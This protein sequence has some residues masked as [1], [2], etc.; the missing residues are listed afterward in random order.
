VDDTTTTPAGT[1]KYG[2]FQYANWSYIQ[3]MQVR[4]PHVFAADRDSA[5]RDHRVVTW[6]WQLQRHAFVDP[7]PATGWKTVAT[8]KRQRATAYEDAQAPFT[9]MRVYFD[10]K[11][12]APA[13][14][15]FS[16]ALLRALVVVKWYRPDGSVEA[17]VKLVP[18]YYR[19]KTVFAPD[20]TGGQPWCGL[21][22]TSG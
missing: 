20:F 8:S 10:G 19:L 1:C 2:N 3:W 4:A 7:T 5:K 17:T 21:I 15:T 22:A 16:S 11:A 18:D 6:Q 13:P 9:A 14:P 12:H